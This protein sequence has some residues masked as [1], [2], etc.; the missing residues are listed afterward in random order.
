MSHIK[1][2][3]NNYQRTDWETS[4]VSFI[5]FGCYYPTRTLDYYMQYL[6]FSKKQYCDIYHRSYTDD[7]QQLQGMSSLLHK[8]IPFFSSKNSKVLYQFL[9]HKAKCPSVLLLHSIH[10]KNPLLHKEK[11]LDS[12]GIIALKFECA[13]VYTMR[14]S[15][16]VR[17][18]EVSHITV[19]PD[20]KIGFFFHDTEY[21][22]IYC[23][24]NSTTQKP[25]SSQLKLSKKF[26]ILRFA[27]LMIGTHDTDKTIEFYRSIAHYDTVVF[28]EQGIFED[29]SFLPRNQSIR[30]TKIIRSKKSNT[31]FSDMFFEL[32]FLSISK[33]NTYQQK[34]EN[35]STQHIL[36]YKDNKNVTIIP[37]LECHCMIGFEIARI[38]NFITFCTEQNH[39]EVV[40]KE[41]DITTPFFSSKIC[42]LKDP[43]NISIV[44]NEIKK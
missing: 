16:L 9:L 31:M 17:G 15:M 25:V 20:N 1:H 19:S 12:I 36:Q 14:N 6:A 24:E 30:R 27:G 41:H 42:I 23:F 2:S 32:E 34:N 3:K 10:I 37:F 26:R 11:G 39:I 38:D 40:E 7:K 22:W 13:N 33:E 18:Y 28:D 4:G 43:N 5:G 21:N 8:A 44:C 29:F 35:V